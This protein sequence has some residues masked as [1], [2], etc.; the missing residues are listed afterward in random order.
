MN[1]TPIPILHNLSLYSE[2]VGALLAVN[3]TPITD[4]DR[5]ALRQ[6]LDAGELDAIEFDAVVFRQGPNANHYRFRDGDLPTFAASFG[7]QPFLR[8]H[9]TRT[10]ES[11]DGTIQTSTL[12][13][14]EFVQRIR[15][16]TERGMRS[17]LEGQIDRFS[18]GWYFDAITC[19]V[20]N[21]D[22]M[23]CSHWPGRRYTV[24]DAAGSESELLAEIIF[25]KPRGKETSAVNAPAVPGTRV[26]SQLCELKESFH[27]ETNPM[28]EEVK[29]PA[30]VETQAQPQAQPQPQTQ[31][32]AQAKAP[33]PV[34]T[35]DDIWTAYLREQAINAA[36]ATSRLPAAAQDAVRAALAD[37]A[38]LKPTHIDAAISLQ[39]TALAQAA[40]KETV[41]GVNPLDSQMGSLDKISQALEAL[42]TGVRPKGV[43]PLSGIREAYILLSGDYEMHGKFVPE[44]V[45]LANVTTTTMAGLVANAMNKRVV[46]EFQQYPRWWESIVFEEDFEN[47]NQVKWITLGGVGEL[48]EVAEGAPYT[49]L[50][51]D[52]QIETSEWAKKGGYLGLTMEMIDRDDTQ[53]FRRAPRAL[54]QSA[55][56]TLSKTTSA[57]FTTASG[58][59]PTMSDGDALFHANHNNLG[60]TALSFA[61]WDATRIAMRKQTELNSA[62]RMGALTAPKYLLVPSDLETTA[63]QVLAS[64]GEPGTANND[65]NP[66]AEGDE[67]DTRMRIARRKVVVVDL[68]T[69][70]NNW[71]AVADPMLYPSI[72]MGYRYGRQPE[73][74]S[75]ASENSGLMFS[76]DVMPIKVRFFFAVGPTDWRGL[77]KHNVA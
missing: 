53:R 5:R 22:W 27:K 50:N 43:R 37:R 69:D 35:H 67:H 42:L 71:A 70:T 60:T 25:E 76:N 23:R 20:C 41:K 64:L 45:G 72:G 51:W 75:V 65:E 52:D 21:Q 29:K 57:I 49:E 44:N 63:V 30:E 56:L 48:P 24:R 59:G 73:I 38:D 6:Q 14:A 26:L 11:R 4:L 10:I 40:E 19:T 39:R 13:Q 77:Y 9:N 33:E 36:L 12:Q 3:G 34:A 61:A 55:W 2:P 46:N 58:V 68:W 17:F 74:F 62:E 15:L 32:P 1:P 54:A 31:T 28:S 8:D 18:I 7:S 47:L 16:T 66:F